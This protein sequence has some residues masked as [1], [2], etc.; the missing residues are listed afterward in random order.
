MGFNIGK[1]ENAGADIIIDNDYIKYSLM[2]ITNDIFDEILAK[3]GI[4]MYI[5]SEPTGNFYLLQKGLRIKTNYKI[6]ID[7]LRESE[8]TGIIGRNIKNE[9][10]YTKSRN[11]I[12]VYSKIKKEGFETTVAQNQTLINE[13][14]LLQQV[15]E[16]ETEN[17]TSSKI[18]AEKVLSV[19]ELPDQLIS[20]EVLGN[21]N[22]RVYDILE[23]DSE[24]LTGTFEVI[25]IDQ[26]A[27]NGTVRG[28][29]TLKEVV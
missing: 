23:Y 21:L 5:K 22:I 12:K 1:I 7:G 11:S 27:A 6:D 24:D 8:I 17:F 3:T 14:G 29:L 20:F 9:I 4:E 16:F 25:S 19:K 13:I 10:D 18:Q 28:T 2:E 15:V 26:S